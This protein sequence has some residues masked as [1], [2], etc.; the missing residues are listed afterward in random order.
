VNS[1]EPSTPSYEVTVC[2]TAAALCWGLTDNLGC[3][4]PEA[5]PTTTANVMR[6]NGLPGGDLRFCFND[7]DIGV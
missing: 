2:F 1:C 4:P 3:R 6:C 5:L 7:E